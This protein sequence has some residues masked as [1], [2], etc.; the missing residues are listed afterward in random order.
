M[1]VYRGLPDPDEP[2]GAAGATR[3]RSGRSRTRPR[4]ASIRSSRTPRSTR[5]C[6]PAGCRSSSAARASTCARRSPT[7]SCRRRPRRARGSAGARSTT[8]TEETRRTRSSPDG[9]PKAA[10][11]VHPNDRRRVVRALE[12]VDAGASLRPH[13]RPALDRGD[14]A[15]HDVVVGLE[16]AAGDA[17]AADRGAGAGDVRGGCRDGGA[18]RRWR[19][20]SRDRAQGD[21]AARGVRAA[22]AP[23]RSRR[24]RCAR[25][26]TRPTSGSGCGAFPASS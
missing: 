17:G 5:S 23:R 3:R 14:A 11:V 9:I 4:S 24:S 2:V 21:R 8:S 19:R 6:R 10:A 13:A 25:A 12:L 15:S 7:S 1:Q 18:S 20:R 22:R 16:V 26:S